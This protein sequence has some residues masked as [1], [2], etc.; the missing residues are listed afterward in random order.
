MND[1]LGGKQYRIYFNPAEIPTA[2]DPEGGY[3]LRPELQMTKSSLAVCEEVRKYL[4]LNMTAEQI[5]NFICSVLK[6]VLELSR[7]DFQPRRISFIKFLPII[8]GKLESATGQFD[9]E[10]TPAYIK[11][12]FS[13]DVDTSAIVAAL[14][15]INRI[16]GP[17][18]TIMNVRPATTADYGQI[19]RG[20]SFVV[21]GQYLQMNEGDTVKASWVDGETTKSA[22]LTITASDADRITCEWLTELDNLPAGTEVTITVRNHGDNPEGDWQVD[23]KKVTIMEGSSEE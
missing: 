16:T 12:Q 9:P 11:M 7:T 14:A 8:G 4:G 17:R 10:T 23:S 15:F 13:Q 5:N 6:A 2:I 18:M 3:M 1:T 20:T 22:A 21:T 19:M